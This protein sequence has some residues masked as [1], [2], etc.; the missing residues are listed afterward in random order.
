MAEY[1]IFEQVN[2][3]AGTTNK[4]VVGSTVIASAATIAPTYRVTHI[5]GVAAVSTITPPWT[6]DFG[7]TLVFIADG[8][9]SWG[10]GGNIQVAGSTSIGQMVFATYDPIN[11]KWY[12]ANSGTVNGAGSGGGTL[13]SVRTRT[14]TANVNLGATL[15]PAVSGLKYRLTEAVMISIGGAAATATTVDIKGTQSAASVK[16]VAAAVAT[17]TQ[18]AIVKMTTANTLAAGASYVQNDVNT[19]ITIGSTT[20]NLATSTNIDTI[21]T[22]ALEP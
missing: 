17:L 1:P 14:T 16:L 6:P 9:F 18:D 10:T 13:F 19:A 20:N 21:L 22:F 7:G 2:N 8:A 5:S 3:N 4:P 15:L 11:A 12:L